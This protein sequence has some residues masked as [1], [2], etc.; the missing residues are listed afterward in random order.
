MFLV[1]GLGT[2]RTVV[3]VIS[4]F[5]AGICA[6]AVVSALFP[7]PMVVATTLGGGANKAQGLFIE[8]FLTAQLVFVIIMVAAEKHKSTYLAPIAIGITFFLCEL[9]GTLVIFFAILRFP[10]P[11]LIGN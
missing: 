11:L 9:I 1:G 4:Q 3:V 7:G 2:V 6:A 5:V 8:M 10:W